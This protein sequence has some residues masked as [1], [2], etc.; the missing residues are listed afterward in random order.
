MG[1]TSAGAV[2]DMAAFAWDGMRVPL[3]LLPGLPRLMPAIAAALG[4]L[5][6]DG[7]AQDPHMELDVCV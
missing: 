6:E 5:A 7:D 2:A 1:L 3:V 4:E